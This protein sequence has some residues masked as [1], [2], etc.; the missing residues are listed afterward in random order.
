MPA[1]KNV[2]DIGSKV[3]VVTMVV[4]IMT[5][6]I[7]IKMVFIMGI[8]DG[9]GRMINVIIPTKILPPRLMCLRAWFQLMHCT[10]L[11]GSG[12]VSR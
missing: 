6:P 10:I 11:D 4:M 3:V 5:V 12:N 9:S 7:E 2:S 1:N 8:G